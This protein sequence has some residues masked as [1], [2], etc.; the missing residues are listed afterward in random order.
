MASYLGRFGIAASFIAAWVLA[1]NVSAEMPSGQTPA[2]KVKAV[3]T[4]PITSV[5]GRDNYMAYCAVCHGE[6]GKGH[7][8]AAPAMKAPVPDLTTIAKRNKGKFDAVSLQ[9]LISGTGKTATPAHGVE[10]MPIWG[11][12]FKPDD[13]GVTKL[14]IG[15]LVRYLES[16]QQRATGGALQ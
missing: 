12:V 15:N 9:Y 14:R 4:A 16:I 5:D 13:R 8:P 11:D 1:V 2:P 3:S 7:G 10:E 6:D